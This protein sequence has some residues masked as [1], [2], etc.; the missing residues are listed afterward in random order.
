MNGK[1]FSWQVILIAIN[2]SRVCYILFT[3]MIN[4]L[5]MW[6]MLQG[7]AKLPFIEEHRLLAEIKKVE[8]TLSVH[9]SAFHMCCF[10]VK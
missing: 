2:Q 10:L 3:F 8:G 6:L 9:A 5:T 1:R 4:V 7:V